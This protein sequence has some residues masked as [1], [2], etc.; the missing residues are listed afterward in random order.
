MQT[1]GVGLVR[2]HVYIQ[3]GT[4]VHADVGAAA[5]AQVGKVNA[6]QVIARPHDE[7]PSFVPQPKK[8]GVKP[9]E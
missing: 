6:V 5:A 3:F 4:L 9:K 8:E 1:A 7:L 2:I